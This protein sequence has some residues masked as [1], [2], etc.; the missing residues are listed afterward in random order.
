MRTN[1]FVLST[2]LSWW[3]LLYFFIRQVAMFGQLYIFSQLQVGKT[4][5]LFG[6]SSI[7]IV[8]VLG[9]LLLGE[10]LSRQAYIGVVFTVI[11]FIVMAYS[12]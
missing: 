12:R 11:A 9:F 2:F 10:V 4:M 1:P 6:A 7:I 5:A 3:F 8:N